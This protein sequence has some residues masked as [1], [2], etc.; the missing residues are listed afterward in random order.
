MCIAPARL[1]GLIHA[2]RD[3]EFAPY[4][5]KL[6]ASRLNVSDSQ[7]YSGT[8]IKRPLFRESSRDRASA[9]KENR[10][11]RL[12]WGVCDCDRSACEMSPEDSISF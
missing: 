10:L 5:A 12:G 1:P 3:G 9:S 11:C 8:R 4:G 6:K 2:I 7:P